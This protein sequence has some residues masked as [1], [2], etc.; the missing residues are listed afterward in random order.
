MNYE[1]LEHRIA[2]LREWLPDATD[3]ERLEVFA[4]IATGYCRYCGRA[5]V[6]H[7]PCHCTKDD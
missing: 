1:Q 3:D 5:L 6:S 2:L 7:E 4:R